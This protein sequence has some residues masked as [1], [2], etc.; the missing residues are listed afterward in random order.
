M[1]PGPNGVERMI[2]E[3]T[4]A[5]GKTGSISVL[6]IYAHGNSGV[7]NVAGDMTS[8]IPFPRSPSIR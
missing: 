8:P 5:A 1:S 7:I 2:Y 6:G 3:V 4:G